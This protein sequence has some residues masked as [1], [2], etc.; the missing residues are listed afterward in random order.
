MAIDFERE[1]LLRGTR[2]KA[3]EARR[4]LLEELVE[5]GVPLDELR[6]AV[7]EDRLALLPVERFLEG[8]GPRYT[9]EEVANKAGVDRE[10]LV[11]NR[12]ALGLPPPDPEAPAA[13]DEDVEMARRIKTLLEAGLPEEGIIENSRVLGLAT[14]QIAAAANALVGEALLRPGD[15]ELEAAHRY[16]DAA[17][18]LAPM[19][20][21]AVTYALNLHLRE[22]IRQAVIGSAQLA[23]GS[24]AG[25]Q[26]VTACFADLVDFTR[27]GQTL[28]FESL[29]RLTTRLG[30]LA[31][32]VASPPVRLVKMLGDA[33]M[34]V[35]PDNDA[36]LDA[37]LAL[38]AAAEAED[39]GEFPALR[40]G[41][42]RGEAVARGGDWYGHPINL[43]SRITDY[44][45]PS[46]VLCAK[47]VRDAS[48][49]GYRWSFAGERHLKGIDGG[50]KLYR[51]RR[52]EEA[53]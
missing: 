11:R 49:D 21:P 35:S 33:A 10:S 41:L 26:E 44:A 14:A 29:S 43:A 25:A 28:D 39:G 24:I 1:G 23:A 46:S 22:Q 50:V 36:L 15:T 2:G 52:A 4:K 32:D 5:D 53:S 51:V 40:A 8:A 30:E 20:G 3:R 38:V 37:A 34:L 6:R 31:R 16:L 27:L 42:A 7:E 9:L 18:T 19:L 17:R 45:Y 13:T 47:E 12:A 48:R